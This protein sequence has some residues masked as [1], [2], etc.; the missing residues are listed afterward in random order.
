MYM[1][2]FYTIFYIINTLLLT[3]LIMLK[4]IKL[5][6]LCDQSLFISWSNKRLL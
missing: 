6:L 3:K 4:D 2:F 1:I 5:F